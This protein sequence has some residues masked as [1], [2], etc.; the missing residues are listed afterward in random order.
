MHTVSEYLCKQR[1]ASA[2]SPAAGRVLGPPLLWQRTVAVVPHGR[3][4]VA[5]RRASRRRAA[6]HTMHF[7]GPPL[8]PVLMVSWICREQTLP[9]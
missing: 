5:C 3:R 2:G 6:I 9:F 8:T 4:M 7:I 1:R